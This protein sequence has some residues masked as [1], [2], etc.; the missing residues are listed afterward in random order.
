MHTLK[1]EKVIQSIAKQSL[2]CERMCKVYL[3]RYLGMTVSLCHVYAS[4]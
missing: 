2:A 4:L 1:I 3:G